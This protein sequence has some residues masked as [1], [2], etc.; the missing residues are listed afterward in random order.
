MHFIRLAIFTALSFF[1][2]SSQIVAEEAKTFDEAVEGL[3][4]MDGLLPVYLDHAKGRV[5]FKLPPSFFRQLSSVSV[6]SVLTTVSWGADF[7]FR[8]I[9]DNQIR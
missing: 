5:L 7:I 2:A 1:V 6:R 4:V 3:E 9:P 8:A